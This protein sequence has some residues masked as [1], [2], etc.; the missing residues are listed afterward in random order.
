M[1]PR[2]WDGEFSSNDAGVSYGPTI[3]SGI[4]GPILYKDVVAGNEVAI[5]KFIQDGSTRMPGFRYGL[6]LTEIDSIIEYL[7]TVPK[8]QKRGSPQAGSRD[9]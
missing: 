3:T 1:K 2:N 9:P 5:K 6:E 7:K 4:Y 8:P